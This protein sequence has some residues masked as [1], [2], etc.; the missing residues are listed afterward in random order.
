MADID[1]RDDVRIS[2]EAL[3]QLFRASGIRR[4]VDDI[5]RMAAMLA[6]ANLLITAWD[7]TRLV[8]VARGLTD[9]CYCC[10]LSDLAVDREYQRRGI[11][12]ELVNRVR[13]RITDRAMLLL[14]A[15]P[16]AMA[17][18][19]RIGFQVAPNAWIQSRSA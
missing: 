7:G 10:Y 16:E 6:H 5:E 3:A 2:A 11:G 8:G 15:A 12:E 14:L 4:P 1:F 18:Y 13:A 19:P 17:Y 9:F